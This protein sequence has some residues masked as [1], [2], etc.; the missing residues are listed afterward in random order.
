MDTSSI[1]SLFGIV[2]VLASYL[3]L[4]LY[5]GWIVADILPVSIASMYPAS[6]YRLV[7]PLAIF[8]LVIAYMLFN[9]VTWRI[10]IQN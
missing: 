5:L 6:H 1:S 7:L 10:E 2:T 3:F 9:W 4:L 8:V